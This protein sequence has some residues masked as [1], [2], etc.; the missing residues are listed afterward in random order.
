MK[1]VSNE[2][3]FF[4]GGAVRLLESI[5][6]F[7]DHDSRDYFVKELMYWVLGFV[8]KTDYK[9]AKRIVKDAEGRINNLISNHALKRTK[10]P[11]GE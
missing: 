10:M 6:Q 7:D 1:R 2:Q 3:S 9:H 4:K 5:E 8:A 11:R